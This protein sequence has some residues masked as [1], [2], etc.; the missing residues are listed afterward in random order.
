M[1]YYLYSHSNADGIFYI[2]KGTKGRKDIFYR[3]RSEEWKAIAEKGYTSKI[4]AHG[5]EKD[6]FDLERKVIKSLVEQ[7][8]KLVNK[9]H[10]K[11]SDYHKGDKNNMFGK[12]GDKHP[13]FGKS[14]SDDAKQRISEARK[15]VKLDI[16]HKKKLSHA[17]K[18]QWQRYKLNKANNYGGEN[19]I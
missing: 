8:V 15:G 18:I 7:G 9:Q 16:E 1:D 19:E 17:A 6:I 13:R 2:G 12:F 4:E 5:T 10:N 3:S 14:Q 11:N